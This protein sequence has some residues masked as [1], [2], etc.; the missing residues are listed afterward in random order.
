[1]ASF[2]ELKS[3]GNECFKK[4]QFEL[5]LEFY[6][7]ALDVSPSNHVALSNRSLAFYKLERYDAA[8]D[9]ANKCVKANNSW[10]KGYIRK[11]TALNALGK[12]KEAKATC[13]VGFA[14][15]DQS[16]CKLFVEEWLKASRV[17]VDPKFDALKKPPWSDLLPEVADLFCDEYCNLLYTV[18]YLRLSDAQSISHETMARCVLG[19]VE[20][21]DDVLKEFHFPS[22]SSLKEWAE[23]A[24]IHFE[25]FPMTDRGKL[26]EDLHKKTSIL[27][28]WLKNDLHESLRLVL[29][30]VLMLASSAMLVRGNVLCQA[31]TGH[32]STEYLG[33][34]CVGFFE[35]K[36]LTDPRYSAFHMA[37]LSMILNSYRL[38]GVLDENEIQLVRGLCHKLENLLPH[39]PKD[40]KHYNLIIKH[41]QHTVQVFREIC[42]KVI[43]GFTGSHDPTESLSE[44][45][46]AMLKCE[47]DPD[48][49]MDVALK[50]LNDI[51]SKTK[52]SET[53][54]VSH[55]NFIDAEN[56]LYIT[57]K[58]CL[59][60]FLSVRKIVSLLVVMT[61]ELCRISVG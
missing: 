50:Y 7:K 19:A 13:V 36:V 27:I 18:T 45:E 6:A 12:H 29:D 60:S 44:L 38:R 55:I 20:I 26:M 39:L 24:T 16:L 56:M 40:H 54:N 35:Q 15:Q 28:G 17:L 25:S 52:K 5:A 51:A 42:A 46:L 10:A 41:Y 37:V 14:L 47:D 1:M 32:Y 3:K 23:T 30:P 61:T 31:Y 49:T 33:C 2:D 21:A 59:R 34:A 58:T 22:T 57:G 9:E 53:S 4:G 43:T 11:A 8:L 48:T